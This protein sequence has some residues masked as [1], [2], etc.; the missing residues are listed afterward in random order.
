MAHKF[1]VV[2][3]IVSLAGLLLFAIALPIGCA[4]VFR[5]AE[6][7]PGVETATSRLV[8]EIEHRPML[9]LS[10]VTGSIAFFMAALSLFVRMTSWPPID[11]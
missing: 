4:L 2:G 9:T 1:V 11:R 8:S 6:V 5:S 7:G 3:K 10:L